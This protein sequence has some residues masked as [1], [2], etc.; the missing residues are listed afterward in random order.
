MDKSFVAQEVMPAVHIPLVLLVIPLLFV[1]YHTKKA[2]F[3]GLLCSF[4]TISGV[5]IVFL[6]KSV[7]LKLLLDLVT[8]FSCI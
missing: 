7:N 4:C 1:S 3:S 6:L 8:V 2:G 5:I